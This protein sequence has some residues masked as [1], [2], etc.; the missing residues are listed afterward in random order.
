MT[1]SPLR[2]LFNRVAQRV[3]QAGVGGFIQM[4]KISL[5]LAVKSYSVIAGWRISLVKH[6]W[7]WKIILS[8]CKVS[9]SSVESKCFS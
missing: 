9:D 6:K 4:V 2:K 3:G 1:V 7:M 5:V 8:P